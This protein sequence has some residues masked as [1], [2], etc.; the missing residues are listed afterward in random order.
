MKQNCLMGRELTA[1][2]NVAKEKKVNDF[3]SD[4]IDLNQKGI[5]T[6]TISKN[7]NSMGI[8]TINLVLNL[9]QN[10]T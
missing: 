2:M 10:L 8:D 9:V 4:L 3:M 6:I 7:L 1:Q 5:D